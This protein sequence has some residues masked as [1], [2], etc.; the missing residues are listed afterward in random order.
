MLLKNGDK[1]TQVTM[2]QY[3]LHILCF[4]PKSFDGNFGTNMEE[5]LKRYQTAYGLSADG[6]VGDATWS[7]LCQE[8]KPIQRA[9][10]DKG[11]YNYSVDGIA[12][13]ST[14]NAVI[15]FQT[16]KGLKNDGMVGNAT[17]NKL[18]MAG[19]EEVTES[20]FPLKQGA[21][22]DKVIYLQYGLRI[23]CCSPGAI[24][25]KFGTGTYNAV[26]K[27]QQKYSL[28][29]DGIVGSGTWG[30]MKSLISEIQT[31]LIS[32]GYDI[33]NVDGVAGP[34]TYS[35]VQEFQAANGL[36]VD[37]QVGPATREKLL[38][39]AS[40]GGNDAFPLKLGSVGPYVQF[41]QQAL[42]IMC[43]NPKTLA[44]TFDSNT[45]SAVKRFQEKYGLT[46]DGIVGTG[47][48]EKLRSVIKPIQQALVNHGY[49]TVA[50]DGIAGSVTYNAVLAFQEANGLTADG[51]VGTG[52]LAKLGIT[53][54]GGGVGTI[55]ATLK[56]GSDGSLVRYLQHVL[57][58][59]GYSVTIN[60]IFDSATVTAVKAFQEANGLTSDGV[61]GSGTWSKIFEKYKVNVS[62]TGITKFVNVARHELS[63]GFKEDNSNNIT[64]YG[65]WYGMQGSAWCAM[66]VSWCAH[67][68]GIIGDIVPRYAYCP[69]GMNWYRAQNR[70]YS[71]SGGYTPKIGDVVFF[72]SSTAN[73][74][75]HTGLVVEVDTTTIT[76][77]EGNSAD[78]VYER[79]YNKT[80]T[81]IYGYGSNSEV[82]SDMTTDEIE[83]AIN[84]ALYK[85]GLDLLKA[86]NV[87]FKLINDTYV[88]GIN[89]TTEFSV[90]VKTMEFDI[91]P[92]MN[93]SVTIELCD[94]TYTNPKALFNIGVSNGSLVSGVNFH[95]KLFDIVTKVEA[96][97][98]ESIAGALPHL[99]SI[100]LNVQKGKIGYILAISDDSVVLGYSVTASLEATE[101][102]E[103]SFRFV[104]EVKISNPYEPENAAKWGN[105]YVACNDVLKAVEEG[106]EKSEEVVPAISTML[107]KEWIGV[108]TLLL[109]L[110]FIATLVHV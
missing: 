41:L 12:R 51:M 43:I 73:R 107:S 109:I 55:S 4:S 78:G 79:T 92:N 61:V 74:V 42:R 34:G 24:D 63:W 85:K 71:R 13:V 49:S 98:N 53:S 33:G 65:Q 80:N 62:G 83:E 70:Y 88:F 75:A 52:T 77:I 106:E 64:P 95:S 54:N 89:R 101:T 15:N 68:A 2:V 108:D 93:A 60:G 29:A 17:R 102:S 50:V 11:Y 45:E 28:T 14:Y 27:F 96:E 103:K 21:V 22:G 44:G 104:F 99:E 39:T 6:I 3:A 18:M 81:Y 47:T 100:E 76:T 7:S 56:S 67:Q 32:K 31:A 37:G 40:D 30:K 110:I 97:F 46:A 35:G 105:F 25:G 10:A 5:A 23:L 36:T 66:F 19:S 16:A 26:V 9:L 48:W 87:P 59:L 8:I 90:G 84:N 57:E 86:C 69:S 1:G 38:G 91:A 94:E 58:A 20:D 72:W 82:T